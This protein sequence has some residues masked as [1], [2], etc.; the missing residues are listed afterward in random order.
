[1]TENILLKITLDC[2]INKEKYEK[3]TAKE[4]TMKINK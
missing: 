1:M 3:Q 4:K 2:L